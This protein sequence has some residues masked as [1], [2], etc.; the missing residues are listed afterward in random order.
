MIAESGGRLAWDVRSGAVILTL[1]TL[2]GPLK[3]I[4]V[5][6]TD[7]NHEPSRTGQR[8]PTEASATPRY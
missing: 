7:K 5:K 3:R 4:V 6:I 8:K 1:I 2:R